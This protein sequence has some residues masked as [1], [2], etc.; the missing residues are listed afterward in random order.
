[1]TQET[2]IPVQKVL[3]QDAGDDIVF[4]DMADDERNP[5][6]SCGA[7]CNH[8]RIS[9]YQGELST[10]LGGVVPADL[11]MPLTS[12][13]ACMKGTDAGGRCIALQG[14]PGQPGIGCAIYANRPSPCRQYP[15]WLDDGSPNPDCNRLRAR[16]GLPPLGRNPDSV[17][18]A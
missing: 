17:A 3:R 18:P 15:V 9:F 6:L 1:M 11:A 13:L 7:C 12:F 14:T 5:C 10:N 16:I 8:F 2:L 4:I